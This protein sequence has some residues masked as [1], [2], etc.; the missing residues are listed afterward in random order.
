MRRKLPLISACSIISFLRSAHV[1]AFDDFSHWWH[2]LFSTFEQCQSL[3]T[4]VVYFDSLACLI[5][6]LKPGSVWQYH[7]EHVLNTASVIDKI[8]SSWTCSTPLQSLTTSPLGT[9]CKMAASTGFWSAA[10]HISSGGG[11]EGSCGVKTPEA[12]RCR[13]GLEGGGGGGS[14]RHG[15]GG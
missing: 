4:L 1:S 13:G 6:V 9:S 11:L 5:H 7:Q 10:S 2:Q 12:R 15:G 14:V 3:T 8:I